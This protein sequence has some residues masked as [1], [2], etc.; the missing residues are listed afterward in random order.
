MYLSRLILEPRNRQTWNW[1]ADCRTL[2]RTV[3]AGF[4][5]ADS[6]RARA[7]LG[8]LFRVEIPRDQP[9][10]VLVQSAVAPSWAF[11]TRAI[12]DI[13]P[14]VDIDGRLAAIE[15][16]ERYRL[17]L[18]ANPTRRVHARALQGPD[19][20]ELTTRGEWRAADEI[21]ESER[22]GIVRRPTAEGAG[23]HGKRVAVRR[24]EERI[25]WLK[26]QGERCGFTLLETRVEPAGRDLLDARA[27]IG[28]ALH[29]RAPLDR[30]LTFETCVFEGALEVTD[31]DL[32]RAAIATGVGPG[33][34]FG[35]GLFSIAKL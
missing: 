9:P 28:G 23:W 24:E 15:H 32:L 17:R 21:P 33:K 8:V 31:A 3:M 34:A 13:D 12:A 14:P 22:T 19:L 20:R 27:D 35:C 26:R 30:R 4:G 7:E 29:D 6:E 1:L 2:H 10:Q 18:R 5:Q 16:G 11:E 25:A